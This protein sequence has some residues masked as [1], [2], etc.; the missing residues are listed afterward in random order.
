MKKF[1]SILILLLT[2]STWAQFAVAPFG[3]AGTAA[4]PVGNNRKSPCINGGCSL[5]INVKPFCFGTN[6]RA[7]SSDRQMKPNQNVAMDV[8]LT[9]PTSATSKDNIRI[10]FP[11]TV[12]Y[13]A[14]GIRTDCLFTDT[15]TSGDRNM[16]CNV[17]SAGAFNYTLRSW[18]GS[19]NSGPT[20]FMKYGGKKLEADLVGTGSIDPK[21]YC[22]YKFDRNYRNGQMFYDR[23]SCYFPSKL[24]DMSN[25]I[26][27]KKEGVDITS[28][29]N[30]QAG[31]NNIKVVLTQPLKSQSTALPVKHGKLIGG[32]R[33]KHQIT[34]RQGTSVLASNK[35][36]E[37][38]DEQNAYK[39]FTTIVK[40][41][42]S[43]G[44]CGG[45]YSPLMLFF[46]KKL[47]NFDGVSTFQ[48][49][50]VKEGQRINW[51]EENSPGYFLA[52]LKKG[53]DKVT[54]STQLFG[55]TA[56]FENGFEALKVHDINADGVIN[57]KDAVWNDLKLWNDKNSNGE[58]EPE[59]LIPLSKKGVSSIG[60][61][62]SSRDITKWED[63]AR[64]R[65]K[66]QFSFVKNGKSIEGNVF[67][68]W[69]AP[70]D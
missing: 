49:Y 56:I 42:G 29:T 8:V 16:S 64:A 20:D 36:S 13:A 24:P 52:Y 57:D 7:Y 43:E 27:V 10:E 18:K 39:S 59:E 12:T 47:P 25:Q 44:L 17:P 60:L 61:N 63:R 4:P 37:T 26:K 23:V 2:T 65:E 45:Y 53:E 48:L 1:T 66:G 54:S 41:P 51:P 3:A 28:L 21:I 38:F 70:I 40:I 19:A 14:R 50:G 15:K 9:N 6:L 58:S 62:Y 30:V 32:K 34:Y 69:L 22:L 31:L 11:A 55:Q 68:V 33:P 35:E 67:D 5:E 46:D